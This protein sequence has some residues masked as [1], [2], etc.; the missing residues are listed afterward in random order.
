MRINTLQFLTGW[1]RSIRVRLTIVSLI[2]A[3]VPGSLV[4]AVLFFQAR[5]SLRQQV[6]AGV[7]SLAEAVG[8]D[9]DRFLNERRGNIEILAHSTIFTSSVTSAQDKATLLLNFQTA[10]QG[11]ASLYFT[12]AAGNII[13]ATDHTGGDQSARDWFKNAVSLKSVV[14]SD[15][16]F[17]TSAQRIVVTISSPV[18]A[19][20]GQLL[21]VVTANIDGQ[22]FSDI[23]AAT[24]VGQ[25]GKVFFVNHEGRVVIDPD[26]A[27]V[28]T[29][30]SGLAAV[31]A[32]LRGERGNVVGSNNQGS[33]VFESYVPLGGLENWSAIGELPLGELDSPVLDLGNRMAIFA[34][35]EVPFLILIAVYASNRIIQPVRQLTGTTQRLQ[36][37]LSV[38]SDIRSDDEIGQLARSFNEM[39]DAIQKREAEVISAEV[40]RVRAEQADQFKSQFL[41]SMSHEL[42]TPLNAIL[43]FSQFISMG[44]LGPVNAKQTESLLEI[45]NSGK[46]LL[47]LINDVLDMTKIQGGM[48]TLFIEN[49]VALDGII[50]AAVSTARTLLANKP[51]TIVLDVDSQLPLMHGDKRRI[52]QV[53]LNLLS[54]AAKFTDKGI[55]TLSVKKHANEIQFAVIDTGPG[56]PNKDFKAIFEPFK[57]SDTGLKHAG[58]T[59]LGL[60]ISQSLVEAHGGK[61]WVESE[62]GKG[63]SFMFTLPIESVLI[64]TP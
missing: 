33:P 25:T 26:I 17:L 49:D 31:Q 40:A 14:V 24:H 1:R 38:R 36:R 51:V 13:A 56:I 41:A 32:V 37:D 46:H 44:M 50:S 16:Y 39:A 3:I 18:Y 53:L 2:L 9:I 48:L 10:Y 47:S 30:V 52:Q 7:Q 28:F 12:D 5:D 34:A 62:V 58:G 57:Q 20:D 42:R 43:N 54:N 19:A 61:L 55:I 11:Y 15:M 27:A 6:G 21:G 59:G 60:P 64:A 8:R 29:D 45:T 35:I 63:A 22:N 23:A 4:S